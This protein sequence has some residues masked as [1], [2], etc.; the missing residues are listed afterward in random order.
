MWRSILQ[1]FNLMALKIYCV[2]EVQ[3]RYNRAYWIKNIMRVGRDRKVYL[4]SD[5]G[6][7]LISAMLWLMIA[8]TET[9]VGKSRSQQFI[10]GLCL[11]LLKFFKICLVNFS[12]SRMSHSTESCCVPNFF[13]YTVTETG[14]TLI[15][16]IPMKDST[17]WSSDIHFKEPTHKLLIVKPLK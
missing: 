11:G 15:N 2:T 4:I 13:S 10:I 12:V 16:V 5:A 3:F 14:W 9:R 1:K 8:E 6:V 17:L 7:T